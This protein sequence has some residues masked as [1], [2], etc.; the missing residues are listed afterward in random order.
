MIC[1]LCCTKDQKIGALEYEILELRR[2]MESR[3]AALKLISLRFDKDCVVNGVPIKEGT[4]YR[5]SNG[6]QPNDP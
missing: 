4:T 2:R 6:F 3:E 5:V 1:E